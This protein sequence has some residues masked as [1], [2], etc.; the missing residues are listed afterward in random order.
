MMTRLVVI[1]FALVGSMQVCPPLR[2][3]QMPVPSTARWT[4]TV[5]GG[6]TQVT[7]V[8]LQAGPARQD[9]EVFATWYSSEQVKTFP[10]PSSVQNLTH[11][12]VKAT[13]PEAKPVEACVKWNGSPKKR[14]SFAQGAEDLEV[15]VQ[16]ESKDCKC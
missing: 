10:L 12:Y 15:D 6:E 1:F 2:W 3:A 11:V 5:C 4:I 7:E 14:Y 16:E 8:T 13:S 9:L